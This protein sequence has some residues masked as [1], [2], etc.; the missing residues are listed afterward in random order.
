[1][2]QISKSEMTIVI[3]C[4]SM[5]NARILMECLEPENR[6]LDDRTNILARVENKKLIIKLEST[7]SISSLRTTV[8]DIF[9]TI[10]L[11]ESVL[12]KLSKNN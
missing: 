2:K 10:R 6:L 8:D 4:Q 3:T 7:S 1:M 11:S 5:E 9:H 12:H